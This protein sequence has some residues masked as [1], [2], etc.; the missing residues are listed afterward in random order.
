MPQ[1]KINQEFRL[2]KI[3]E[4]RNYLTEEINQNKLISKKPKNTYRVLNYIDHS[5]IVISTI[6]GCVS[7]SAFASLVGIPIGTTNS[8][9][10]LKLCV[11]TAGI[12]KYKSMIK[13]K[14]KKHD[15]IVLLAKSKLNSIE[16]LIV[17]IKLR[18]GLN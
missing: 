15:K 10:G 2:K 7:I 3:D 11:I 18:L 17:K 1:E 14:K 4:I 13:K 5:F 12:K 6:T 16:D 9:I 8:A